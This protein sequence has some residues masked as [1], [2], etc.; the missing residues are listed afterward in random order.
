MLVPREPDDAMI[1]AGE[2]VLIEG[3]EWGKRIFAAD[4][5]AAMIAAALSPL[6]AP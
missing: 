6:E 1:E 5:Y 4:I 3:R 2:E